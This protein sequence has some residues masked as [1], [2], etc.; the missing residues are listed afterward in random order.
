MQQALRNT[1]TILNKKIISFICVYN[2][3]YFLQMGILKN[4]EMLIKLIMADLL[5]H[6]RPLLD[7]LYVLRC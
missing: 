3:V 2:F 6:W 5:C 1:S 7:L 4:Y